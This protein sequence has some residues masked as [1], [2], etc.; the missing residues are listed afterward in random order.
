MAPNNIENSIKDKLEKRALTPSVDA[1]SKLSNKL[2]VQ[3]KKQNNKAFWWLGIAAS[4][5]GVVFVVSQFLN[6]NTQEISIPKI[7][8]SPEVIQDEK[9]NAIVLEN[10]DLNAVEDLSASPIEIHDVKKE[11]DIVT[12]VKKSELAKKEVAK[13]T[14]IVETPRKELS[15]EEQKIQDVVAQVLI[16]KNEN[17]EITDADI[18]QLLIEAQKEIKLN[19]LNNE[20]LNVVDANALL[21]DVE[22]ELD[23]SFRSKVFEAL[24]SSFDSVKTAVAQRND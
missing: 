16:M 11:Q 12:V 18:E 23:Q 14:S 20:T 19:R 8:D 24:K 22:Q 2:D 10:T 9:S 3:E 17:Q 13:T 6:D 21:Q 15:F 5:I 1:W 7:A 4:I